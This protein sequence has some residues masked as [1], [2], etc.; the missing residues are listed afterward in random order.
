M[1]FFAG[2][3]RKIGKEEGVTVQFKQIPKFFVHNG[4]Q[5]ESNLSTLYGNCNKDKYEDIL[6]AIDDAKDKNDDDKKA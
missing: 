4:A 6:K 1:A 2:E 3:L 5:I